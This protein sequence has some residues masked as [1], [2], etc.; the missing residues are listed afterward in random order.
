MAGEGVAG[1]GSVALK[2]RGGESREDDHKLN[3]LLH[4]HNSLYGNHQL[5]QLT[6]FKYKYTAI[7]YTGVRSRLITSC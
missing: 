7:E 4:M 3:T 5:I 1:E 6:K 2:G